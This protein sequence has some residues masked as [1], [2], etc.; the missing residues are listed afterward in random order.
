MGQAKQAGG[1]FQSVKR[2][3]EYQG[4]RSGTP[5]LT[6]SASS[7]PILIGAGHDRGGRFCCRR[8]SMHW[9]AR[10]KSASRARPKRAPGWSDRL[11]GSLYRCPRAGNAA[12]ASCESDNRDRQA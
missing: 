1:C 11:T 10:Y 3:R 8:S 4:Y 6:S 5:E 9:A 12:R 7:L 2:Q